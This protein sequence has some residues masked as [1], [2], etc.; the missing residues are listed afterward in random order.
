TAWGEAGLRDA[1]GLH[2]HLIGRCEIPSLCRPGQA[3][4]AFTRVF[5]TLWREPGPILREPSARHGVWVPAFARDDNIPMNQ[6]LFL[7]SG[8]LIADRRF[9]FAQDLI[10][11]GDLAAAADLLAQALEAAPR[12]ASA[13]F[14]LGEV[15]ERAGDRSG[16]AQAFHEALA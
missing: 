9:T 7:S 12:F 13:W 2:R 4:S 6:P 10:A 11:R 1:F 15:R 8:D 14:T 16:A 3:I 5:D